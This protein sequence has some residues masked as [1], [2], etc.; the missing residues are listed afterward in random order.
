MRLV[1]QVGYVPN[2]TRSNNLTAEDS[3]T[4]KPLLVLLLPAKQHLQQVRPV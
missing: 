2:S 4:Y 3:L 1:Q